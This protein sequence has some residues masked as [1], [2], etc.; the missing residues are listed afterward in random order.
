MKRL[1]IVLGIG[2]YPAEFASAPHQACQQGQW[3]AVCIMTANPPGRGVS[4]A[5]SAA[6]ATW[7]GSTTSRS[8]ATSWCGLGQF[9]AVGGRMVSRVFERDRSGG[10]RSGPWFP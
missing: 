6:T 2:W 5:Q 7:A 3:K 4:R 10:G 8:A 9:D 1:R